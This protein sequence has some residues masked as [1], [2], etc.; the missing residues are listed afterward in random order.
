MSAESVVSLKQFPTEV[1]MRRKTVFLDEGRG[2]KQVGYF[3]G[4]GKPMAFTRHF[5]ADTA[6]AIAAEVCRIEGVAEVPKLAV[7]APCPPEFLP[8]PE[9]SSPEESPLILPD[10]FAGE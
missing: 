8:P 5:D 1:V 7:P 9:E 4:A 2:P 6:A 10:D 3:Y